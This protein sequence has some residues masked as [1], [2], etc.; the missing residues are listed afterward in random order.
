MPFLG[1]TMPFLG[2]PKSAMPFLKCSVVFMHPNH[3]LIQETGQN[4]PSS[5]SLSVQKP[6]LSKKIPKGSPWPL[7][8]CNPREEIWPYRNK[9][10]EQLF[11][12]LEQL[13]QMTMRQD[14]QSE[15]AEVEDV[16][17]LMLQCKGYILTCVL[18]GPTFLLGTR[19]WYPSLGSFWPLRAGSSWG[20]TPLNQSAHVSRT[21]VMILKQIEKISSECNGMILKHTMWFYQYYSNTSWWYYSNTPG[22]EVQKYVI[23]F[24]RDLSH[25]L[26]EWEHGPC[27]FLVSKFKAF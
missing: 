14:C 22:H 7:E 12:N 26:I 6:V 17:S 21:D 2:P 24:V 9:V 16:I 4:Y 5:P 18:E 13:H 10:Q 19:I 15:N 1:A 25:V 23:V 3:S 20:S 27:S 11:G 8:T